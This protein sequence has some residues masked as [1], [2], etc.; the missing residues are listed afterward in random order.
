MR[1]RLNNA[2]LLQTILMVGLIALLVYLALRGVPAWAFSLAFLAGIIAA[3]TPGILAGYVLPR[4]E[5]K[6]A[7]QVRRTG[8]P[9]QARVLQDGD[10][11]LAEFRR[12]TMG[13]KGVRLLL[14]VP[15][16]LSHADGTNARQTCMKTDID[17]LQTLKTGMVVSVRCDPT[18]QGFIVLDDS[19]VRG[20]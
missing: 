2:Y 17:A 7:E 15:V 1:R 10:Q 6:R 8:L 14:D 5:L 18:D 16:M 20:T 13:H 3:A 4:R 9:A 12:G 19:T 11:I